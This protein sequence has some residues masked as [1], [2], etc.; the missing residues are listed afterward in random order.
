MQTKFK[1]NGIKQIVFYRDGKQVG[2]PYGGVL[3][4]GATWWWRTS[5]PGGGPAAANGWQWRHTHPGCDDRKRIY[6]S[7]DTGSG[8]RRARYKTVPL[9]TTL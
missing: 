9:G 4:R 3:L 2:G 5:L 6:T 8:D 1:G 7:V